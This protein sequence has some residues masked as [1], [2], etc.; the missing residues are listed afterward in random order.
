M[1]DA[2]PDDDSRALAE[3]LAARTA[4]VDALRSITA[5]I[6]HELDVAALLGL[7]NRRAAVLLDAP[8]S[9]LWSWNDERGVFVPAAWH[10]VGD[11]IRETAL[12]I[13][14]GVTGTV[15]ARREGLIVDDYASSPLR[16][17]KADPRFIEETRVR[18]VVSE[19]LLY[20]D[21]LTGVITVS[22]PEPASRF[23]AAD[24]ELLRLFAGQAAIALE[25]A[26]LL[27]REQHAR[28]DAEAAQHDA[29]FLA[30]ASTLLA[31]SLDYGTTFRRLARLA[32]ARLADWC[33]IDVVEA[34]GRLSRLATAHADPEQEDL[35]AQLLS[36]PPS[37]TAAN[38]VERVIATGEAILRSVVDDAHLERVAREPGHL[39]V[40]RVLG[41][42]SYISVP[43]VARGRTLGALSLVS[44]TPARRYAAKD[45]A[46]A[47]DLGRRAG[48]AIDNAR[49]FRESEAR[50]REAEALLEVG[51]LITETLD[52][53]AVGRR[54]VESVQQL[55]ASSMAVLYRVDPA[56]GDLHLI[57]GSGPHVDWNRV[58]RRGT[59]TVGAAVRTRAPVTTPDLLADPR[60]A[61]APDA[62]DR[63][64]R[65]GYQA[66]L[67]VPIVGKD[68][69]IGA[70]AAGDARGRVYGDDDVRLVQTFAHQAA[71]ALENA[72]LYAE[73]RTARSE[74][75]NA[76]RM[77]DEF[78]AMLSHE[79]RTPLTSIVGWTGLLRGGQLDE[80]SADRA[81]EPIERNARLQTQLVEDL[82]DVSAI[83]T[84]KFRL[85][86]RSVELS[87]VV[88][89][90]VESMRSAAEA[91]KL[92]LEWARAP[93]IGV[94]RGDPD[95]IQ[96]I[97][98]NLLSNAI[99]FT[100]AGGVVRVSLRPVGN[101][102]RLVVDD[103]GRGISADFLPHVFEH[104]RQADATATRSHRG[105]GLGLA[106]VRHL[107]ELH[108]GEV[109]A[110]SGGEGRG[111]TF[112]VELP[113]LP[114]VVP[115]AW[116]AAGAG[117][118][119]SLPALDGIT[120]LVV[121]DEADTRDLLRTV[122]EKRGARVSTAASAGE[123]RQAFVR[124]APRVVV[125]DIM[126]PGEDGYQLAAWVRTLDVERGTRTPLIALTAYASAQ[127]RGRA[128]AAGFARPG[129]KPLEPGEL[130]EAVAAVLAITP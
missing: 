102:A 90:A 93:G 82:L 17:R 4:Q 71:A 3:A 125:S 86:L 43:L 81:L 54:I 88:E 64:Q 14:D 15:A 52:L 123:A 69:V 11:W 96:Q 42:A 114:D 118:F 55:T 112:T 116:R 12:E 115:A 19:P 6:A 76:N 72:R 2:R 83:I 9:V 94:V 60:I 103:T 117:G 29:D 101:R 23:T 79:L 74:A 28:A 129:P 99:K 77:K 27:E 57:A 130:V 68:R 24:R 65:S 120:V 53:D 41:V 1:V 37:E 44:A 49:L 31:S 110:E 107:V 109:R 66:V 119:D 38:A 106:I 92:V 91:K 34:P 35:V 126:M 124:V 95:R 56:S 18:R 33:V 20:R 30:E 47:E 89:E 113:Q 87:S 46:L 26:R 70:L 80:G 48:A 22:R 122:L 16:S 128:L 61:L 8:V 21:R 62:R 58:L 111:A 5:E 36:F 50:R 73:E 25:N 39:A 108:G 105:L 40:L 84:G 127:D 51:R 121:D 7:I 67:A 98:W 10:G 45:L 13:G 78:L 100:P 63:I 97:V 59:A 75:E 85:D 32:V 104:F